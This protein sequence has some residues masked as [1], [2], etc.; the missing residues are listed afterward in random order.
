[1]LGARVRRRGVLSG[2]RGRRWHRFWID[3]VEHAEADDHGE[4]QAQPGQGEGEFALSVSRR[5][6]ALL[7]G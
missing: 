1:M 3:P 6:V 2:T 4:H 5:R 7:A